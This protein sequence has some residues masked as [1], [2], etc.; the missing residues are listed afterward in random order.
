MYDVIVLDV[1]LAVDSIIRHVIWVIV[2]FLTG[3]GWASFWKTID[4]SI[5]KWV[6]EHEPLGHFVEMLVD[7]LHHTKPAL[8]L[9]AFALYYLYMTSIGVF[10]MAFALG[11]IFVDAPREKERIYETLRLIIKRAPRKEIEKKMEEIAEDTN[12]SKED[13]EEARKL[14]ES[15]EEVDEDGE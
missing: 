15:L 11:I 6:K 8:L 13:I 10:L 4:F 3:I 7:L 12:V 2:A 9:F 1:M 5:R 14:I